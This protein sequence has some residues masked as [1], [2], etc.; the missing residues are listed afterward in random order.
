V[1]GDLRTGTW[2][3]SYEELAALDSRLHPGEATLP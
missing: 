3:W 2:T 1:I